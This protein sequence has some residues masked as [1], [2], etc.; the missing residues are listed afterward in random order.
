MSL[1]LALLPV[2][3]SS[4]LI[5]F[6]R[7]NAVVAAAAG[8]FTGAIMVWLW[9]AFAL[10]L[11]QWPALLS[12]TLVIAFNI[13]LVLLGGVLLYQVMRAGGGLAR[14]GAWVRSM[15][16]DE[17]HSLLV[18][19]FGVGVFFESATGFGVGI[20]VTAPLLIA[21]GYAPVTAAFLALLSQCG[22]TW[23]ALAIGTIVGS[24]LS[25]VPASIMGQYAVPLSLPF[26]LL[27][28][29][30][31]VSAAQLWGG[32]KASATVLWVVTYVMV[33]AG[34]LWLATYWFG[35]ELAGCLA[36]AALLV[37]GYCACR[38][39][40]QP[41]SEKSDRHQSVS[42]PWFALL[43]FVL[44]LGGLMVTRLLHPLK[45]W[46]LTITV[47]DFAP[48]YHASFWLIASALL[49][50]VLL[51]DSR[52]ESGLWLGSSLMQWGKAILAVTGFLLLGQLMKHAGMTRELAESAAAVSGVYF[53][54]FSASLGTLGGFLTA[55][56]ASS[57]ALFME[58]QVK[59]AA[60]VGMPAELAAS[61]QSAAGS[62]ATLASPGR[63]VFAAS[64][65]GSD[66]AESTLLR[67]VLP[68]AL[69]GMLGTALTAVLL[70]QFVS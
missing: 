19:I 16:A 42:P 36:G 39:F 31:A 37:F 50:A 52:K 21:I 38:I 1:I 61:V 33:L 45:Q 41:L 2:S 70:W 65:V 58:F 15:I 17:L 13:A 51:P 60:T 25:G 57:N 3:V 34:L 59:A 7:A 44:L 26:L 48:F 29:F 54:F 11:Q 46:L 5:L 56:N 6:W 27:C 55:S 49:A 64:L 22:V 28:G 24:E 9:P 47:G 8:V 23:G 4:V 12:D 30:S 62:N 66:S 10:P 68:V 67:K 18:M 40:S 43:P 35:V 69:G 32:R 20:L 53:S 63:V 14:I